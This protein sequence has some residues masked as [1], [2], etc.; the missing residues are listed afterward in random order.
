LIAFGGLNLI[1]QAFFEAFQEY[2]DSYVLIGGNA[3]AILLAEELRQFRQTYDY[4]IVVIFENSG[5]SFATAFKRFITENHYE[6]A[7]YG[8]DQDK[9]KV[10]YRFQQPRTTSTLLV[11]RQIE[12]FSRVPLGYK[13]LAGAQTTPIHYENGPSLSAIILDDDYYQL[14]QQSRLKIGQMS[15]LSVPALIYFKAKAHLDIQQQIMAGKKISHRPNKR[16][17]LRD[18]CRLCTLLPDP[19]FDSRLVPVTCQ[20]DLRAFIALLQTENPTV[21]RQSFRQ[22]RDFQMSLAEVVEILKQLLPS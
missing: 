8:T 15:I 10:Y 22:E 5:A 18:V 2:T 14:L 7:E 11:P 21:F 17:H 20:R 3:T 12:L 19:T 4:D 1:Y 6:I 9:R 16:K 13:L